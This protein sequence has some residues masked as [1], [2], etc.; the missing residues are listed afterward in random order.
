MNTEK[1][2]LVQ[3]VIRMSGFFVY[4]LLTQSGRYAVLSEPCARL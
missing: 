1:C 4:R 3:S 2:F